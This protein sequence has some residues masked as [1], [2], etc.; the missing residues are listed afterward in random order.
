MVASAGAALVVDVS[1]AASLD[2]AL[3]GYRAD[4]RVRY[5]EPDYVYHLSDVPN[6][7][8]ESEQGASPTC[9]RH[10]PGT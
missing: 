7:P 1:G 10:R 4:G 3:R 2:A 6:D 9:R 5:A 8:R